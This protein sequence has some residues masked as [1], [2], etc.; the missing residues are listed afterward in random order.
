MG[1]AA[2]SGG[3]RSA[4]ERMKAESAVSHGRSWPR[5]LAYSLTGA[6]PPSALPPALTASTVADRLAR[7]QPQLAL[8]SWPTPL[9]A[10]Q[11]AGPMSA[12]L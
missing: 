12:R 7:S 3:K 1:G 11:H 10:G 2:G 8:G 5:S 6:R 4:G 9:R